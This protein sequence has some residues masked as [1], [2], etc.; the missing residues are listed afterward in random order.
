MELFLVKELMIDW[1]AR[2]E[3]DALRYEVIG[4]TTS[5]E[6]AEAICRLGKIYDVN[7]CWAIKGTMPQYI[8]VP[9]RQ[10]YEEMFL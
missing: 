10:L 5:R 3:E 8:N 4:Y 1:D 7:E 2:K 9:S 6:E